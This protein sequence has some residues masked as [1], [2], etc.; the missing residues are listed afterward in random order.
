MRVILFSKH[1]QILLKIQFQG[2]FVYNFY[3]SVVILTTSV[4]R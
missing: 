4:K 2:I 1:R 3:I